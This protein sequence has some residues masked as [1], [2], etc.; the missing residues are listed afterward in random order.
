MKLS[1]FIRINI[2]QISAEWEQFAATLLPDEEFS[3]S[4]LRDGIVDM[5]IE[6]ACDMDRAQSAQQQQ[7]KSQGDPKVTLHIEDAAERHALA[8]VKMGLSSRQLISEFRALRATVI[9][10]WQQ[11]AIEIDEVALYDL[12]RFNESID[13]ALSE[14]A[15]RHSEEIDRSREL[16]L[17]ILGHDLRNPLSAILGLAE[18]QL[19]AKEPERCA[20]FA[21]QILI[22]AGRMSHMI[23]DLIELTRVQLGSGIVVNPTRA[24]LRDV[25]A[26]VVQEMQA[27][28]PRRIFY[29]DCDDAL[30]GEWDEARMNQV[31]SNL[32]G[33]A[34]QHGAA[35]SAVT[36]SGKRDRNAIE[37]AVHNEGIPILADVIPRLFD[38]LFRSRPS[39]VAS[40]DQSTSLGLGLYIAKEIVVAHGGTINAYSSAKD[41]TTFVVRLP[42]AVAHGLPQPT[43]SSASASRFRPVSICLP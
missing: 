12:T 13:Q 10:L 43:P 34:I 8:R 37:L 2:D 19:I 9:R 23:T 17:G 42:C 38:H 7:G 41:G 26:N 15:V 11:S 24:D 40:D 30:S 4:V 29:L 32:L 31:I 16:F 20:V 25:C 33:N 14:A 28:Y 27:A 36:L 21:K 1:A 22:S 6:I 3:T 18:L 39:E 35:T 5:L